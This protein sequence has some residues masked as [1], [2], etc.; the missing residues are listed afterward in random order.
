MGGYLR[1]MDLEF[2]N[3][4]EVDKELQEKIRL[5]RN[6]KEVNK[7]MV[8]NHQISKDEHKKWFEK[9]KKEENRKAWIIKYEKKPIGLV[10]L[11]NIDFIKKTTEWGFYI[12]D[13]SEKGKGVG[14][15]SLLKLME[16]V[17]E[18]MNFEKMSTMVVE[19]NIIALKLYEKFGF[20][21]EGKL[22][23]K[24]NRDGKKLNVF[25]MSISKEKWKEIKKI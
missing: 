6:S 9:L 11:T 5:W 13:K 23:E 17:F 20:E 10:Q 22:K 19:N 3:I 25:I 21:K 16:I 18:E 14:S 4:L 15:A 2:Q 7:F 12:Y 24:L 8:T 1:N